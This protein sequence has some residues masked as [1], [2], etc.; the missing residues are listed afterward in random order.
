ESR[1]YCWMP[2]ENHLSLRRKDSNPR[3][4]IRIF[5]REH[6]SRFRKIHFSGDL[7]HYSLINFGCLSKDRKRISRQR[8][9]RKDV[10]NS[11]IQQGH[12]DASDLRTDLSNHGMRTIF[13]VA[14]PS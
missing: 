3:S 4:A 14:L 7:L 11:I 12:A 10:D 9:G 8:L 6:E 2:G 13:P 5:R 1:A